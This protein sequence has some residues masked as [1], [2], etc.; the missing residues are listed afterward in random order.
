MSMKIINTENAPA[1]VGPYSQAIIANG[2]VFCSGQIPYST[3]GEVVGSTAAEQAVQVL[4]NL[5][6]VLE[7]A[8]SSLSKVVKTS[9]FL[10]DMNDFASVNEV[11]A[12]AFGD[13]RPA[14][15]TVEASGLP[16]GLMVEIECVALAS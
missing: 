10:Q 8:G 14:R 7:A 13:H 2:F 15:A 12:A 6:A 3:S 11:Y 5:S 1:A 16:K 4:K 9:I